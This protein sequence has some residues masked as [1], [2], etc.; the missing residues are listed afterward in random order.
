VKKSLNIWSLPADLP[1]REKMERARDAGFAGIE[2]EMAEEGPVCLTSTPTELEAVATMA[3]EVGIEISSLA[4]GLFWGAPASSDDPAVR[5]KAV[6]IGTKMIEAAAALGTDAVLI[7]PGCV[8]MLWDPAAGDVRYDV[9]Y[10]RALDMLRALVP[11]AE[12]HKVHVGVENVW[13]MLF[14]SP[15]ELR[16]AIDSIGSGYVG[17]YFDVGNVVKFGFPEHWIPILGERIKR[18]HFK[19]YKRDGGFPEG[20]TNLCE[21]DVDWAKVMAAFRAIGY[22]GWAAAEMLPPENFEPIEGTS[23]AMDR[24]FGM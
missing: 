16:D 3:A 9:A 15:L 2:L 12:S 24:I 23:A 7:I 20:F 4:T 17:S 13:N 14:L 22:E 11:A 1:L 18:V 5:A 8:G 21:G 19:D 10:G 6:T